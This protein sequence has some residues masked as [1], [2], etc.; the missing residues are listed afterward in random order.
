LV[1]ASME[2][3]PSKSREMH[4][5][6]LRAASWQKGENAVSAC[7]G[8][9]PPRRPCSAPSGLRPFP[10]VIVIPPWGYDEPGTLAYAIRSICPVSADGEHGE[11][12]ME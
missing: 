6:G 2:M 5:H 9:S 8:A 7:Y 3:M 12:R 11:L 1:S 10:S 4:R